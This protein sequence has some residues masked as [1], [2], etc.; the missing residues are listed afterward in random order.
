MKCVRAV[1]VG[2]LLAAACVAAPSASWAAEPGAASRAADSLRSAFPELAQPPEAPGVPRGTAVDEYV[3]P[4]MA[5]LV[6][7]QGHRSLLLSSMPLRSRVGDGSLQPLSVALSSGGPGEVEPQNP[8]AEV[9]IA[10]DASQGFT[11]GPDA[12]HLLSVVPVGLDPD[13]PPGTA[14]AGQLLFAGAAPQTDLLLRPSA[15]GVQTFE[16]LSGAAAPES[17]SY[18]LALDPG[19]TAELRNGVVTVRQAGAVI[20]QSVPPIALDADHQPVPVTTSLDHDVLRLDVPHRGG[21]F[22][23]PI[24]VDPDW[25]SSYDYVGQPGLGREGWH[26][27]GQVPESPPAYYD[28]LINNVWDPA[29]DPAREQLGFIIQPHVTAASQSF[30]VG[31]GALLFFNAPGTTH[32]RSIDY[33]NVYRFN[34]RDRQT[35]RL[36][37]YGPSFGEANDVFETNDINRED[38]TLPSSPFPDDQDAPAKSAVMWMFTSPCVEGTDRNCPPDIPFGTR[39]QLRVGSVQLVLTDFDFPSTSA[40]GTL[41]DLQDRWSN[42]T[43]SRLLDA[44]AIDEGSGVRDLSLSLEHGGDSEVLRQIEAPCHPDHDQAE[45]TQDNT[46]CPREAHQSLNVDVGPLPDGPTT[47]S[48]D[49]SD[50]ADNTASAGGTAAAFSIYLDRKA[51]STTASGELY[52]AADSWFRPQRPG[53]LTVTGADTAGGEGNTSGIAHNLLT[54]VDAHGTTVLTRGADTCTPPGPITAPCDPGKASTFTVDPR[55]LPEGPVRFSAS[56]TD[57]AE[58]TSDPA[59]WTVRLDRTPPAARASGDLLALTSQHTNSTTPT[60]VTLQGRDAASGVARLQL[61]ASNSDGEKLLADRDTCTSADL[62]PTDGACPHTPSVQVSVDPGDLP[63]GPTT[64]IA[65]AI[66]Q[67]GNKSVDNQDWDTYVDHTPPDAPDSVSVTQTSSSS[68]QITWPAVVDQPLGSGHVSY[69]YLV[70]ANGQPIGTWQPT[71]NPYAQAGG[72]PAGV[73]ISVQV[74]AIDAADNVGAP[75]QGKT[76]LRFVDSSPEQLYDDSHLGRLRDAANLARRQLVDT[77]VEV[78]AYRSALSQLI[79]YLGRSGGVFIFITTLLKPDSDTACEGKAFSHAFTAP[80]VDLAGSALQSGAAARVPPDPSVNA[81]LD[82]AYSRLDGLEAEALAE[83]QNRKQNLDGKCEGA[84]KTGLTAVGRTRPL[85]IDADRSLAERTAQLIGRRAKVGTK[86]CTEARELVKQLGPGSGRPNYVVYWAPPPPLDEDVEYVG[87][88]RALDSRC[89]SHPEER[90][91][92]LETLNLPPLTHENAHD[93][94]EALIARFGTARDR[95]AN[96]GTP[97]I[98]A[99]RGG[100]LANQIHSISNLRPLYCAR[101]LLGQ[102]ILS[103]NGYAAYARAY[104]TGGMICPGVR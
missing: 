90:S 46:L 100:Q 1:P 64:F 6:D 102:M 32:I 13:T 12:Q 62:D 33:T 11:I 52:T 59:E 94:E 75:A 24:V 7:L 42:A 82:T 10:T 40:A 61:I 84:Q 22:R 66:D 51:P 17:F 28:A 79:K 70:T 34:D 2:L 14:F 74:R 101:L 18:R 35:L 43:D 77:G 99:T 20:A 21:G 93:V 39:T 65:R 58:N 91:N 31:V 53:P 104:F 103:L 88:S 27:A 89:S 72:L 76:S 60:S 25:T 16:Q 9:R 29:T 78:A 57:L 4:D 3:G 83:I 95:I 67:A 47:F 30:P 36:G 68:V 81:L 50:L 92:N 37:L 5:R 44:S 55:Q 71:N 26:A 8:V 41:R 15:A 63:D 54:A 98:I 45:P 87:V 49:A 38:I 19:Q 69:Q 80:A 97:P 73:L 48:V 85:L 86:Q 23:Y 96:H 56:S